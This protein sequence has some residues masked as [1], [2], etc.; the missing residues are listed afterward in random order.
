MDTSGNA[1]VGS[2]PVN[3]T[4][5]P[6][7]DRSYV[8]QPDV[9]VQDIAFQSNRSGNWDIYIMAVDGTNLRQVTDDPAADEYPTWDCLDA[10]DLFFQ[11]ERDG[12][13]EIYKYQSADGTIVRWTY[14]TAADKYPVWRPE[15][16]RWSEEMDKM[17]IT[18]RD[19]TG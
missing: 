18:W 16:I 10:Q 12:N 17:F 3:L 1:A 4:N 11:S 8:W 13:A 15:E 9:A 7:D 14:H 5:D 2:D 19:Q 6:A